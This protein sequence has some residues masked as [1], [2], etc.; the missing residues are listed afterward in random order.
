LIDVRIHYLDDGGRAESLS[1]SDSLTPSNGPD[2][3][4]H[5]FINGDRSIAIMGN[6]RFS[7]STR[8]RRTLRSS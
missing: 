4:V 1:L 8:S 2:E 7:E 3:D 6:L 5:V